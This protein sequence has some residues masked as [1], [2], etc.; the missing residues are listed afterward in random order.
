MAATWLDLGNYARFASANALP[1][2]WR[3]SMDDLGQFVFA[4]YGDPALLLAARGKTLRGYMIR[5]RHVSGGL[6]RPV[7]VS[8][9]A[10]DEWHG[11]YP[12]PDYTFP[13]PELGESTTERVANVPDQGRP[14]G[15]FP[16][17]LAAYEIGSDRWP[18]LFTVAAI[19]RVTGNDPDADYK[20]YLRLLE[21]RVLVDDAPKWTA[22]GAA[23]VV[24]GGWTT[25][26]YQL[27][28]PDGTP[29]VGERLRILAG[30]RTQV[31]TPPANPFNTDWYAAAE[32][33]TDATGRV[34]FHIRGNIDGVDWLKV[35]LKEDHRIALYST[36]LEDDFEFFI[37]DPVA[38]EP[39]PP[40]CVDY[41]EQPYIAPVPARI[42]V[43][44]VFAW[45]SGAHS[46]T[47]VAGDAQL[48]FTMFKGVGTILGLAPVPVLDGPLVTDH[49]RITHGFLGS[50]SAA[51]VPLAQIIERG[52]LRGTIFEYTP[53]ITEFT[54]QRSGDTVSY[55][56]DGTRRGV[57]LLP[58]TGAVV[59][60]SA[61][62]ATGDRVPPRAG[63]APPQ[64]PE[65]A[66]VFDATMRDNVVEVF[67]DYARNSPGGDS[68]NPG[69]ELAPGHVRDGHATFGSHL[70][71]S[72]RA[73][74]THAVMADAMIYRQ[75]SHPNGEWHDWEVYA[76]LPAT[77]T[78]FRDPRP[79]WVEAA[80]GVHFSNVI[81]MPELP[82]GFVY[83]VDGET[84]F[85]DDDGEL[86]TPIYRHML[87]IPSEAPDAVLVD[88]ASG[89][90]VVSAMLAGSV[91][92]R[93][94]DDDIGIT[95]TYAV[96]R[97]IGS[98]DWDYYC[99]NVTLSIEGQ[100]PFDIG[101]QCGD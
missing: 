24:E 65:G 41:P 63:A 74:V 50:T 10:F 15:R 81:E 19:E 40:V 16:T 27:N 67:R 8:G 53:E 73:T 20:V 76:A 58:S 49:T 56:V 47:Q 71:S 94:Y 43:T 21:F 52:Q 80:E 11:A 96:A 90:G 30:T 91:L 3:Q 14:I 45:D 22:T 72:A 51:G 31:R 89:A 61:L 87:I 38:P 2:V 55:L 88:V 54:I 101:A 57:S 85:Y 98:P 4:R 69:R 34:V 5:Q 78:F 99:G 36:P 66:I 46:F 100:S 35:Y 86:D 32:A 6:R 37:I 77:I 84:S 97:Y 29:I 12:Q 28:W 13:V 23:A 59:A 1:V 83:S 60:A 18:G 68:E 48:R 82:V 70:S 25:R 17:D 64:P 75:T 42:E 95:R 79:S 44:P 39:P 9:F 93:H 62:Y 26:T 7:R 33:V 92:S